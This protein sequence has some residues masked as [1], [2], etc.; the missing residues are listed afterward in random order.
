[1]EKE[2][3]IWRHP[4]VISDKGFESFSLSNIRLTKTE[5]QYRNA[6]WPQLPIVFEID[7]IIRKFESF[8]RTELYLEKYKDKYYILKCIKEGKNI[9]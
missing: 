7:D 1:M 6:G 5:K 3:C 4:I 2:N 8:A 9:F